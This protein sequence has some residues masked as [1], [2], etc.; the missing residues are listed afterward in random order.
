M[1]ESNVGMKVVEN[2]ASET[3]HL[4]LLFLESQ[5]NKWT[6]LCASGLQAVVCRTGYWFSI[7]DRFRTRS[8]VS[9]LFGHGFQIKLFN[10]ASAG[11][12]QR[13][14]LLVLTFRAWGSWIPRYYSSFYLFFFS[15]AASLN[16]V[17]ETFYCTLQNWRCWIVDT[18]AKCFYLSENNYSH[19]FVHKTHE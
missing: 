14:I 10:G 11:E 12:W 18:F 4:G 15:G 7:P 1:G 8:R 3:F 17:S 2:L 6:W 19:C 9:I 5:L 13:V 16:I